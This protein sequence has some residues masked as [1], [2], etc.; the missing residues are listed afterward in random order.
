MRLRFMFAETL[1]GASLRLFVR[2]F[3]FSAAGAEEGLG[4]AMGDLGV[5]E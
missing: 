3:S 4:S 5:V 2:W 1:R